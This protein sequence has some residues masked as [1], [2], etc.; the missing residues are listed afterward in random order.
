MRTDLKLKRQYRVITARKL[1]VDT[2]EAILLSNMTV[3]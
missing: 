2:K 1:N 3:K